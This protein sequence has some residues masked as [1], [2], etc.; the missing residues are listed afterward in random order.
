MDDK[1]NGKNGTSKTGDKLENNGR[2]AAGYDPRRNLNGRPKSGESLADLAR[3]INLESEE[4]MVG[5]TKTRMEKRRIFLESIYRRAV[6]GSDAAARLWWNYSDGLPPFK[7][8]ITFPEEADF[9]GDLAELARAR[10]MLAASRIGA[11]IG[12][13]NDEEQDADNGEA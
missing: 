7:G 3:Q 2:F 8:Q 12:E 10:R 13:G 9:D 6:R 11:N 4:V 5:E 1:V